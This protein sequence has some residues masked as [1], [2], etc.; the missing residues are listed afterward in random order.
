MKK[1]EYFGFK[2]SRSY[3]LCGVVL[4][5]ALLGFSYKA[6]ADETSTV[7]NDNQISNLITETSNL[8]SNTTSSEIQTQEPIAETSEVTEVTEELQPTEITS[9][10]EP[11]TNNLEKTTSEEPNL[12]SYQEQ[13]TPITQ[14]DDQTTSSVLEQ[15]SPNLVSQEPQ[16]KVNTSL[17][18]ASHQAETTPSSDDRLQDDNGNLDLSAATAPVDP[19][20][21]TSVSLHGANLNLQYNQTIASNAQLLFAVWSEERDQDDLKW[22]KADSKG[23][24]NVP[25]SNHKSLGTYN[26]HTYQSVNGQ[27]TGLNARTFIVAEPKVTT[28]IEKVSSTSYKVTVSNV[29]SYI[30][31]VSLPTWTEANGQDDIIWHE[32]E[33][34]SSS[35]YTATIS[36]AT[37]HLEYGHY[38]VHVYG[39]NQ[40]TQS[41]VGL[42]TNGFDNQ[43]QVGEVTVTPT[44]T[45]KGIELTL[46]A[47]LAAN[48]TIMHAVWSE[49]N[50]QDDLKWYT[51]DKSGKT[52]VDYTG[53]YGIYNIHT[54]AAVNGSMIGLNTSTISIT[55][56]HVKTAITQVD[57]TTYKVTVSDVPSY[58]TDISLPVWSSKND[59]DDIKWT[60]TQTDGEGNY[61]ATISLKDHNFDTGHYNVH[62]YGHSQVTKG[63]VGLTATAGFDVSQEGITLTEPGVS[64]QN[65]DATN[66]TIQIVITETDHSKTIKSVNVAAWSQDN[67]AN[68]H[69]YS[70]SQ[71]VN[72]KII[73]TVDEKYHHNLAGTYTIHAYVTTTDGNTNGTNV[74]QFH[75]DKTKADAS[76]AVAY[77]GTGIYNVTI[78]NITSSGEV[79][80]AV[81]SNIND[82][83]DIIWYNSQQIGD[84]AFGTINVANHKGTGDYSIHVYQKDH[85]TMTFLTSTTFTVDQT[86][87]T[88]PYYNQRDA[89]WGG[90]RYGNYSLSYSGCVPTSLAMV[91][92]SLT[93]KTVLPTDVANYLYNNTSEFN[94]SF[95]GT[96]GQGILEAASAWGMTATPLGS[97]NALITALKEGHHVLAAVQY[98]KFVSSGTHE[99]V[100]KG[101][102]N[103]NT[104]VY[105]PYTQGNVGWYAIN[106]LW[107][108]QSTD[109]I[110]TAGVGAPF[111]KIVDA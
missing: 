91:F 18:T 37:H 74:G 68:L 86:D 22:Y 56:P 41:L 12:P 36:T 13:E 30:T 99:L 105:D 6:S 64:Y 38:N 55:E 107:K 111:I 101:Y 26:I 17:E 19:T 76:V 84:R 2:K 102:S 5:T 40:I 66:G 48:I 45:S 44:A 27:M 51:A 85:D 14:Q 90:N 89:R 42:A 11:S 23:A 82:Q 1:K 79:L 24:V 33:Q 65:Y 93:D 59:Q 87:F 49:K 73:V 88:T 71:V 50:G 58:I 69:W 3:G 15:I 25:L 72:G 60:S 7:A 81:W 43:L 47:D 57:D 29:P 32:A 31:N 20:V 94:K 83:D 109:R 80:Y 8:T 54:Y 110:D 77:T 98:D 46:S 21:V 100:L 34:S 67:Q 9:S 61:T 104:Y 108:E 78:S 95:A 16:A 92:S 4:A 35:T 53:D 103:G 97:Q 62:V 10:E 28:S 52:L 39:Y 70:S 63:L 106:A 75:F 96:S